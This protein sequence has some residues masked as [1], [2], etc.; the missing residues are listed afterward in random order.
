MYPITFLVGLGETVW[1]LRVILL[2]DALPATSITLNDLA[3]VP[4]SGTVNATG[5]VEVLTNATVPSS[6]VSLPCLV[7]RGHYCSL[8]T[9][10]LFHFDLQ[11]V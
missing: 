8:L 9:H 2:T 11:G 4:G 1:K 3:A 7:Y 10:T 5:A 6:I